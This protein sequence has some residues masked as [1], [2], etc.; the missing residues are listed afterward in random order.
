MAI[1]GRIEDSIRTPGHDG[2]VRSMN[3][4][5]DGI[6]TAMETGPNGARSGIRCPCGWLTFEWAD[7][8]N[9]R[10]HYTHCPRAKVPNETCCGISEAPCPG[11]DGRKP[12][13]AAYGTGG[14]KG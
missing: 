7:A 13:E 1:P 6:E 8:N 3:Y 12:C 9:R 14:T 2:E 11:P 4:V 5:L 10:F